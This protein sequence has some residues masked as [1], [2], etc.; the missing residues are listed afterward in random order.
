RRLA[1]AFKRMEETLS[2]TRWLAGDSYSLADIAAAPVIDRIE[3][4]GMADLW[5]NSSGTADWVKRLKARPAYQKAQPLD[6]YRLP[7]ASVG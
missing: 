7:A 3:H 6:T 4:L 2:Q 1:A 5:A